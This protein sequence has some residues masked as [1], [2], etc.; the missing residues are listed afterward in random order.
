M[1]FQKINLV[2]KVAL[3]KQ[4]AKNVLRFTVAV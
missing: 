4:F 3:L 1:Y 2:K